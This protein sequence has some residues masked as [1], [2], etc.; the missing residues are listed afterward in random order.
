M[1]AGC[2]GV[3]VLQAGPMDDPHCFVF[4]RI[5]LDGPHCSVSFDVSYRLGPW[6]NQILLPNFT[7]TFQVSAWVDE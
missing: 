6:M 4:G 3:G 1:A 5:G 2:L 7:P